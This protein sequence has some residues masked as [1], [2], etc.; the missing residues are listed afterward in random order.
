MYN[1]TQHF[2]KIYFH[3]QRLDFLLVPL[4]GNFL[5]TRPYAGDFSPRFQQV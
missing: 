3:F 2:K 4:P 5:S 1:F